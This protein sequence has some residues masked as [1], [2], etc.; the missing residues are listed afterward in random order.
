MPL[1]LS[2]VL[3]LCSMSPSQPSAAQPEPYAT[4]LPSI[5]E[6]LT[7]AITYE[8]EDKGLPA[9]S[10]ALVDGDSVRWAAGFGLAD[11]DAGVPATAETVYRVGS[12]SKLFTALAVGQLVER[13]LVDLDAPVETYLPGL[14]LSPEPHGPV[15]LR[16]LL[17]HRSGL[18]REPPAGHY[19]DPT[20]PSLAATV[21]SLGGTAPVYPPGTRTKYSNAAVAVAGYVIERVTGED[22]AGYVQRHLIEPMGLAH[23]GFAPRPALRRDLATGYMWTYD[24]RRFAAP[25]FEPG[26]LPAAN[27]YASVSDLGRFVAALFEGGRAGADR[28]IRPETLEAMWTVQGAALDDTE[29]FGLGFYVSR[30][31]GERCVGHS[32]GFY[33]HTSRLYALPGQRLGVVVAATLDG[34]HG[35][36]DRLAAYALRLLLAERRGLPLPAFEQTAPV[37][38]GL[39]RRLDGRYEGPRPLRLV[40]RDGALFVED[41]PFRLRLRQSGDTLVADDRLAFGLR[42]RPSGDTLFAAGDVFRRAGEAPPPP[43]PASYGPAIGLY[44]WPHNQLY[45]HERDGGL[46]ALVEWFYDYP[47]R[48]AGTDAY[49]FPDDGLY[50]GETLRLERTPRGAVAAAYVG[51]VRFDR[52]RVGPDEGQVFRI[53][54]VRPVEALRREALAAAPP[55][56]PGPFRAPD[57]VDLEALVPG[58]R[59]DVRYATDRNFMGATFYR[60]ARAFLQRPAA[61]AVARAHADLRAHGYGLIVYD[62]YRPWHV[63]RMFWDATPDGLK[64]F[65]ADPARGSRHNRG[66]AIDVGLYDL[67]TGEVVEMPSGYDEFT[68]RAFADFPGGSERARYHRELL[69]DAMERH[70]FAVYESEWWHFDYAD[71]RLYPILNVPFE[72]L[73]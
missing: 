17:S 2:L 9:L 61:E 41:G 51:P 48:P 8:M 19:F 37:P 56:E 50:A 23:T 36:V 3:L 58:L 4:S 62:A 10:I 30:F 34:A 59:L 69:R 43:A 25:G 54:P 13:G 70:G 6:A 14:R 28:V 18:V 67:A 49:A 26:I 35:V 1:L 7:A 21:T 5:T 38:P 63:T 39:A 22:F 12:I 73:D 68:E 71:W 65:V 16:Q 40:E 46:H 44:G 60:Q 53:E 33:G 27:L 47:L 11:P 57:L 52:L 24:G 20:G 32:G 15:T 45:L 29:G 55:V 64:T 42:L 72:A 66:A 31:E